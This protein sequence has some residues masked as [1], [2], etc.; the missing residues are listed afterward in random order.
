MNI[1]IYEACSFVKPQEN[2][3]TIL[4]VEALILPENK[5]KIIFKD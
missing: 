1:F 3:C 2:K 5:T 4:A